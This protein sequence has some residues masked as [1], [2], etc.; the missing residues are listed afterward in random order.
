MYTTILSIHSFFRWLVLLSLIYAIFRTF[1]GY[2]YQ[3]SFSA[4]DNHTRHWTATIAHI[5]LMLG[6]VLYGVSPLSSLFMK[7]PLNALKTSQT[8]FFGLLHPTLMLLA[9][10]ILTVGS[11]KAKR[12][13]S[14]QD[15]FRTMLIYFSIALIIIL[16]SIPWPFSPWV[17]RPYFS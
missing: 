9:I 4:H 17:A 15:K 8:A 13:Q 14:D 12:K 2:R 7:Q 16:I 1:R 3:L 6:I 11:A 10:I 5:Q